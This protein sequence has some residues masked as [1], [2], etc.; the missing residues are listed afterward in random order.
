MAADGGGSRSNMAADG[1]GSRSNMAAD[2]GGSRWREVEEEKK[3]TP[4]H[5][6]SDEA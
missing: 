2:G 1:G 6:W 4:Q 5:R 3:T